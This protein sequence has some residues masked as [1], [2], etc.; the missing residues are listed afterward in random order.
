MVET[1]KEILSFL[2]WLL[3]AAIG[4][5]A[6]LLA[7]LYLGRGIAYSWHW[8]FKLFLPWRIAIGLTAILTPFTLYGL[9]LVASN[10]RPLR[11]K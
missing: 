6:A 9:T 11:Q 4:T 8:L 5:G 1:L 2:F 10:W 3:V 7:I